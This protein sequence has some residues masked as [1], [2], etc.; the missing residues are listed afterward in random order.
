MVAG[1]QQ[2]T[3]CATHAI[4]ATRRNNI[5][6]PRTNAKMSTRFSSVSTP[7]FAAAGGRTLARECVVVRRVF[8]QSAPPPPPPPPPRHC[9]S[10]SH[11][12]DAEESAARRI[13]HIHTYIHTHTLVDRTTGKTSGG[14][15]SGQVITCSRQSYLPRIKMCTRSSYTYIY[16][17]TYNTRAQK[18]RLFC[19]R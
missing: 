14:K 6:T 17:S 5:R 8:V 19:T 12:E 9:V 15:A 10:M 13:A 18:I 3:L 11:A 16:I 2:G 1:N 7:H 4:D